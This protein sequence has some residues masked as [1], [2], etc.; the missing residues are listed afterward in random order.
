MKTIF[1]SILFLCG[2]CLQAQA[3]EN[4]GERSFK[5]MDATAFCSYI[6]FH[7]EDYLLDNNWQILCAFREPHPLSY[8]DSLG[9]R[10][11]KSQIQLLKIGG[12]LASEN[13]RWHTQIPIFDQGQTRAIRHETRAFADSL[14]RI[15]KPDC[16]ALA[17][18]IADE[19]YQANAYSIFFSYVLDG[20]MWDKL[21]SFDQ[22]ERHATW[23]G[24]YWVMYEPRKNGKIGTNG[25]G[26]LFMNWSD[27]Q[28]YWPSQK[29]LS[30]FS[31]CVQKN[32]LPIQD[33]ELAAQLVKYGYIDKE[34][35]VTLPVFHAGADNRLN[36][37]TDS[38]LTPLADAVKAYMPRFASE[39]GIKDEA[40]ASV[41]FYHE[42]MWDIFDVLNEQGIIHRPAIL[43]GEETGMEHLR[44]ISFIVLEK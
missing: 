15:I 5:E 20:R 26:G 13:K 23:S 36:R 19:G 42:L 21:C 43:N 17:E 22:L 41:I 9:I 10:Y 12:M 28:A 31:E 6:D 2:L 18:E 27:Q 1:L 29:A 33:K 39:Y 4:L 24:L 11:T 7:P 3:Q 16:L 38:I 32:R 35:N 8:L 14:Y 25:Y 44:N 37:L 40:S 34:G 30:G